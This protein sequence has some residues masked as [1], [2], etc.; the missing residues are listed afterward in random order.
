MLDKLWFVTCLAYFFT[1]T[2]SPFIRFKGRKRY[3]SALNFFEGN[4]RGF[5]SERI[6]FDSGSRAAHQ[7][8]A[9]LCRQDDQ[10]K[11]SVDARPLLY[12]FNSAGTLA[13][14]FF[15]CCHLCLPIKVLATGKS[16]VELL[17]LPRSS[18]TSLLPAYDNWGSSFSTAAV[19]YRKCGKT[20]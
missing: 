18:A 3:K 5:P 16:P 11:L 6:R 10:T 19:P 13:S 14:G 4:A 8:F 15:W 17:L 9:S 1:T 7:L 20:K 2:Q 12:H